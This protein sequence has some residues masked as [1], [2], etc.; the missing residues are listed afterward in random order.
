MRLY[1]PICMQTA[2]NFLVDKRNITFCNNEQQASINADAICLVT[3]WKQFRLL[4]LAPIYQKMKGKAFFDGRNQYEKK[5]MEEKGFDYF[6]I[7]IA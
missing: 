1:D 2:K 4:N 3:E 5:E 6:G 7:G